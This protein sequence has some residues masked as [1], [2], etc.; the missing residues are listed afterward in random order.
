MPLCVPAHQP[1]TSLIPP[2]SAPA[3]YRSHSRPFPPPFISASHLAVSQ[4][5]STVFG[6]E[7]IV[8]PVAHALLNGALFEHGGDRGVPVQTLG[9]GACLM[10]AVA[11][12][13][14]GGRRSRARSAQ[15]YALPLRLA[16]VLTGLTKMEEFLGG[17]MY[18]GDFQSLKLYDA[19]VTDIATTL[20]VNFGTLEDFRLSTDVARLLYIVNLRL[21]CSQYNPCQQFC[22]PLIA[23]VLQMKIRCFHPGEDRTIV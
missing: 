2:P 8:D 19:K 18:R 21:L 11:M 22:F 3:G 23:E 13:A 16:T 17:H 5:T 15:K 7:A 14:Y 6:E 1:P 12:G 9:N 10:N 4:G 20:G